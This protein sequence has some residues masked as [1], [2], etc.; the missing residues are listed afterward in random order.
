M[1]KN[2][3]TA[4]GNEMTNAK[5]TPQ[6]QVIKKSRKGDP[7]AHHNYGVAYGATK[8][9]ER[10]QAYC[11]CGYRSPV[12]IDPNDASML[13]ENHDAAMYFKRN[14]RWEE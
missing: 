10:Y 3:E 13:A 2:T 11:S 14:G 7:W 4:K 12:R 6:D 8:S 1:L 5:A 9:G